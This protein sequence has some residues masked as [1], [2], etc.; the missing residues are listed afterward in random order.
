MHNHVGD[1]QISISIIARHMIITQ[2]PHS[3]FQ[4]NCKIFEKTLPP[5]VK[6]LARK[7]SVV[8]INRLLYNENTSRDSGWCGSGDG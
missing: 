5:S 2:H 3:A 8:V 6:V 7:T 1:K 4:N